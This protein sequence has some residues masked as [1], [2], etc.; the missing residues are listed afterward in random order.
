M[1]SS[2]VLALR[3]FGVPGAAE[4]LV[5]AVAL[6]LFVAVA[7]SRPVRRRQ[8]I[9]LAAGDEPSAGA[10]RLR[11]LGFLS[12][13]PRPSRAQERPPA[14]EPQATDIEVS[15]WE[16]ERVGDPTCLRSVA[17]G[18]GAD[19]IGEDLVEDIV[20]VATGERSS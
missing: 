1:S 19:D 15:R 8:A 11:A 18:L 16:R 7:L 5:M 6:G 4:V 20:E 13:W 17:R 12:G 14:A 10:R 3:V 2:I 9:V